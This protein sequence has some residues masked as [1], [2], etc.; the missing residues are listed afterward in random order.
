MKREEDLKIEF[1]NTRSQDEE[2]DEEATFGFPIVDTTTIL[3]E[4][5]KMKN[6]PHSVLPNFYGM[7]T[8][9]PDSFM[10]EFDILCRTYG[11][12][13][14]THKLRIF[15]ATL[16]A[17]ALKWFMGLREHSITSWDEMKKI[18]LKKYQA[19]CRLRDS[20]EDIFIVSHQEDESL[21][22]FLER[23]LYNLQNPSNIL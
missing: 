18:F 16:K 5:V 12:T 2:N 6:I 17:A 22:E 15:L 7:S 11:Y 1:D 9:D 3:G 4:E 14:D 8:K 21:E 20:K 23:F 10:F 19:Y 13:D